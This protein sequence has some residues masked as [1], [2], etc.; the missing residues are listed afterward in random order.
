MASRSIPP[1]AKSAE[2]WGPYADLQNSVTTITATQGS[3]VSA[4]S[5]Q[6]SILPADVVDNI[7]IYA[8]TA[9]GM[10]PDQITLEGG[11]GF[12]T[13]YATNSLIQLPLQVSVTGLPPGVVLDTDLAADFQYYQLLGDVS[14][15]AAINSPYHVTVTATDGRWS[16]EV[17]FDW[18]VAVNGVNTVSLPKPGG[19]G[20]IEV[21]SPVGTSLSAAITQDAGVALPNGIVFPFGF[22]EF[23]FTGLS[24]TTATVT[25]AGLDTNAITDY[26][27]YGVTPDDPADPHWYSF[28]NDPQ[29]GT[30]MEIV[31]GNLVL[32]FV[33]SGRGDDDLQ[34]NGVIFDIGGPVSAGQVDNPPTATNLSAA[35]TYTEDTPLN[36][37]DIVVSDVDSPAVTASLTLSDPA[38]GSLNTATSGA[39]TS[40]YNAATGV[41]SASGAIAD[42]NTLLAGLTFTPALNFN[43]NFTIATSVSDGVAA[44]ITGSKAM[45]GIAVNDP[46]TATNLSAAETYTEDTPL[47]LIDIVVSDVDSPAVTATLTLSIRRPAA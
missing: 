14:V 27:K 13:F 5:F 25:I 32:H 21:S 19:G 16:Q 41:W 39:V 8:D 12:A 22:L 34:Q 11:Q 28:L 45:T 23:A 6:W 35:E 7:S 4:K 36:L 26:Y 31:D 15:G 42:V 3:D 40:T 44:A 29:T 9:D 1:R 37:T 43:G 17:A 38:A 33:D 46:P 47:N 30:G 10:P 24:D 18:F 2:P 20:N